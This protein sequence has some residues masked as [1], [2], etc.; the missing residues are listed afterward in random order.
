MEMSRL[1]T[2]SPLIRGYNG[3]L[4]LPGDTHRVTSSVCVCVSVCGGA[5]S[6]HRLTRVSSV[7][8][9]VGHTWARVSSTYTHV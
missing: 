4:A 2:A 7:D 8:T 9:C 3:Q 1:W 5:L 6:S